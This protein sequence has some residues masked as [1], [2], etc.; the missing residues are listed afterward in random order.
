MIMSMFVSFISLVISL[1]TFILNCCVTPKIEREIKYESKFMS[2]YTELISDYT[3][4]QRLSSYNGTPLT[5]AARLRIKIIAN[6]H[7]MILTIK[8]TK[9][10]SVSKDAIICIKDFIENCNKDNYG[11]LVECVNRYIEFL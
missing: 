10:N 7:M 2:L 6:C 11:N 8:K 4:Y 3:E 9:Q 1:A 5:Y